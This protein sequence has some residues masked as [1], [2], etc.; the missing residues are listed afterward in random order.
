MLVANCDRVRG[1]N[2]TPADVGD[3]YPKERSTEMQFPGTFLETFAT[4]RPHE[5]RQSKELAELIIVDT[6]FVELLQ[7]SAELGVANFTASRRFPLVE[8]QESSSHRNF[9]GNFLERSV[10][11]Q[12]RSALFLKEHPDL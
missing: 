11:L 1:H 5:G 8:L 4:S 9:P 2:T 3:R 6:T 12:E 7:S 10:M